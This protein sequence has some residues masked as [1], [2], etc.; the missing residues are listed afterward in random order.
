MSGEENLTHS[1]KCV[2]VVLV[3]T[4]TQASPVAETR[5][6]ARRVA[7]RAAAVEQFMTH[8]Y[9]ATSMAKIAASA[10]V[11]RPALYQYFSDKDD[12]F[13]SAFASVFEERVDAALAA[14][15]AGGDDV[16][17]CLDGVLQRYDGDL[18]ELTAASPHNEEL[19]AAKSE[20]VARAVGAEVDRLWLAVDSWLAD[21]RPGR[22]AAT[23]ERRAGWRDVL[24]WSPGGMRYD[25]PSVA[26]YRRRLTA[27]ARGVAADINATTTR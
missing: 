10:G 17:A 5:G 26:E 18:W 24:R 6:D 14:L 8:G 1:T 20:G 13:A 19:I 12:I 4:P 16:F 7:I 21:F 2:N 22:D 11:S 3:A 23:K 27:L 9:A 25:Q 15:E